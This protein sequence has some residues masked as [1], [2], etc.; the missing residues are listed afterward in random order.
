MNRLKLLSPAKVNLFLEVLGKRPDGYHEIETVMQTVSLCDQLEFREI[1]TGIKVTSH[2][3]NLP[4]GPRNLI[5]QA[6]HLIK[7]RY[8]IRQGINIFIDKRIPIGAGLGGGSSN[9]AT[10]LVGLNKLW[11]LGLPETE[12][13]CLAAQLG[14]DVPFFISRLAS[15]SRP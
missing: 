11:K 8:Q 9:A 3:P 2:H 4:D 13:S 7:Q 5:Y 14:S 12:L 15:A 1:K 6:A 10:T